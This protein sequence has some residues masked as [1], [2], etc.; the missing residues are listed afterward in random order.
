MHKVSPP[1]IKLAQVHALRS[2]KNGK[3]VAQIG[4][5][6]ER[7]DLLEEQ[8]GQSIEKLGESMVEKSQEFLTHSQR[9]AST[10][11]TEVFSECVQAHIDVNQSHIEAVKDYQSQV[12]TYLNRVKYLFKIPGFQIKGVETQGDTI[13]DSCP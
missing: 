4:Q 12:K 7:G 1:T 9:L 8:S 3:L 5:G 11:S 10:A 6:L 13:Q 2:L